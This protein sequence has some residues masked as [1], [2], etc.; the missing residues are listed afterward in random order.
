MAP[1]YGIENAKSPVVG[2]TLDSDRISIVNGDEEVRVEVDEDG[3]VEVDE[4]DCGEGEVAAGRGED[5]S[6]PMDDEQYGS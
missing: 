1:A 6:G 4:D 2:Y 5:S 3:K